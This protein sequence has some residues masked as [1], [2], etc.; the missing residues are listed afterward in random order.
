MEKTAKD[1]TD[2][3]QHLETRVAELE[4]ENRLLK[5]LLTEKSGSVSDKRED[6][7]ARGKRVKR[8]VSDSP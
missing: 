5:N 2:R 4:K 8:E 1:M 6:G 7:S 3:V